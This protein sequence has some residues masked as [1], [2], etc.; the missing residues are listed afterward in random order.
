LCRD[1]RGPPPSAVDPRGRG[2]SSPASSMTLIGSSAAGLP[3]AEGPDITVRPDEHLGPRPI[4]ERVGEAT[5]GIILLT[6]AGEDD[7]AKG[8]AGVPEVEKVT[9][10]VLSAPPAR[11]DL[12][13][14]NRHGPIEV[15]N[16]H[17]WPPAPHDIETGSGNGVLSHDVELESASC[18]HD[19]AGQLAVDGCGSE[20]FF[21]S[22]SQSLLLCELTERVW[23]RARCSV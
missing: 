4:D 14:D 16:G 13:A 17:Q 10:D 8:H 12:E 2:L 19:M 15:G 6:G 9:L 22:H 21:L 23:P 7:D 3:L 20:G 18:F 11:L 5:Q 1:W